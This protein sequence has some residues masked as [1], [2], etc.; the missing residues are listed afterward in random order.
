MELA[1]ERGRSPPSESDHQEAN[2]FLVGHWSPCWVFG[3]KVPPAR[4]WGA[5]CRGTVRSDDQ[6][7][8]TA[9]VGARAAAASLADV[10]T[11][12]RYSDRMDEHLCIAQ[13]VQDCI[14]P[15]RC[16]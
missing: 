10:P 3:V 6:D 16:D 11:S 1:H 9:S 14:L 7:A 12:R 4:R 15:F 8:V 5:R 13:S 2:P